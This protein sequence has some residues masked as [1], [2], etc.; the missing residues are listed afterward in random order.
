MKCP[1]CQTENPSGS[2][3][4]H[5]CGEPFA[6]SPD[7]PFTK[8]ETVQTPKKEL[9]IGSTF[10]GRYQIIEELGKGGM[11]SVYKVLDTELGE[12]V[13]LKLLKPEIAS[14]EMMIERFRNELKFARKITHKYVCRMFHLSKHEN[15]PYIT[16]EYVSGEDLKS[17]LRRVGHLGTGKTVYIAKQVCEGL[18]EAHKLGVV[19]RDLKPQNIMIDKKGHA[20]IMDFGI[21]RS[22]KA[23][24][25]TTAGMMIGTPDYISPEQVEGIEVDHRADIY[26]MGVI[27]YEMLTGDV[28]F[29]GKTPL[30]VAVKHKTEI[31]RE[32]KEFNPHIPDALNQ[33]VMKCLEKKREKRFQNTD[34]ILNEL[35]GIEKEIPTKEMILE[36]EKT[37]LQAF[38]RKLKDRKII[39]TV[40][41]FIGGGAALIEFAHHILVGHYYLPKE[42]VDYIIVALILA[43]LS[44]VSWQWFHRVEPA[45]RK[46]RRLRQNKFKWIAALIAVFLFLAVAAWQFTPL[47]EILGISLS[48]P[49]P[50]A[51]DQIQT[52]AQEEKKVVEPALVKKQEPKKPK[53]EPEQKALSK[54]EK[55]ESKP[56]K[57]AK[58]T[59]DVSGKLDQGILFFNQG[60]FDECIKQMEEVL[61]LDPENTSAQYFLSEANKK[62]SEKIQERAIN[63]KLRIAQDAFQKGDYRGCVE[64]L[65][66][67]LKSDPQNDQARRLMN[68][69]RLRTAQQQAEALVKEYVH[70]INSKNLTAFYEKACAP[71]LYQ[72]LKKRTESSMRMFESFESTASDV[73]IQFKGLAQAEISFSNII[74][75]VSKSGRKQEFLNG[76]VTWRVRRVGNEWKIINIVTPPREKK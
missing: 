18:T 28:P 19:H 63:D 48:L 58:E 72:R 67:I 20:H 12:K 55:S 52:A 17:T 33:L 40:V 71:Q 64:Q 14:D 4:C 5:K 10:A 65:R 16:M 32:P 3:F 75:G 68:Q 23:K 35:T 57:P 62:K 26:A 29:E 47:P 38:F 42:V 7:I 22:I 15:T 73:K 56:S 51:E 39:P 74:S 76:Q 66:S 11:G 44:T 61:K 8:T 53:P 30:S 46:A 24:G 1:K 49:P 31:P 69:V 25:V 54:P 41:A 6:P 37:I 50:S 21:A 34:E 13:A 43:L 59:V 36:G 70:S 27:L 45:R 9:T 2:G 60:N